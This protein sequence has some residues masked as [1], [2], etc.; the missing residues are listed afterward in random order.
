VEGFERAVDDV[1]TG[2]PRD[3]Y[4]EELAAP[5]PSLPAEPQAGAQVPDVKNLLNLLTNIAQILDVVKREWGESWSEWDQE[6][7]DGITA[8]LIAGAQVPSQDDGEY[9]LFL[10]TAAP[11]E[12]VQRIRNIEKHLNTIR[13]YV[14]EAQQTPITRESILAAPKVNDAPIPEDLKKL[15]DNC[16]KRREWGWGAQLIERIARLEAEARAR[17]LTELTLCDEAHGLYNLVLSETK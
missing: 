8:V 13:D 12:L 3:G 9:E 15:H 2:F 16:G 10:K 11:S 17:K 6:Q 4:I 14:L 7:R 1:R 5:G